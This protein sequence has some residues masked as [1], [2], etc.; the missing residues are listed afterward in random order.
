[1]GLEQNNEQHYREVVDKYS[2]IAANYQMNTRDYVLRVSTQGVGPITI[3]LPPVAEAKGRF[4]SILVRA[5]SAI[6][7]VTIDDHGDSECWANI[8]LNG[9]CDAVLL[10][11]DGLYWHNIRETR[12][13]VTGTAGTAFVSTV[14][15]TTGI[16]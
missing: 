15:P 1:M 13:P 7:T 2:D 3:N 4:Y 6:N 8:V 12:M 14:A 10:Y 9:K 11:S 16:G 5:A